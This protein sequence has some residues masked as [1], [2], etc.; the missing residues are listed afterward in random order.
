MIFNVNLY[1]ELLGVSNRSNRFDTSAT[2]VRIKTTEI[3]E[4]DKHSRHTLTA[5][6]F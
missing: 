4:T 2:L 6:I 5:G 1:A 3:K